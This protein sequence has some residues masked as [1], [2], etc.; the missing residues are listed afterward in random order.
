MDVVSE[1]EIAAVQKNM[2]TELLAALAE[3]AGV[4]FRRDEDS[5]AI[6]ETVR[7]KAEQQPKKGHSILPWIRRV[8]ELREK[9]NPRLPPHPCKACTD[10]SPK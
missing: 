10:N 5:E 3:N 8:F 2:A 9:K 6:K 7:N 4:V 1:V